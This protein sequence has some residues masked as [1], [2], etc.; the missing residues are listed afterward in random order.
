MKY[1]EIFF[2]Y[3][4]LIWLK[5]K[6]LLLFAYLKPKCIILLEQ[7]K[8]KYHSLLIVF[9]LSGIAFLLPSCLSSNDVEYEFLQCSNYEFFG[10]CSYDSL[11]VLTN[12]VYLQ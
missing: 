10:K 1:L 9:L 4:F 12:A 7:M 3:S 11:S 8:F 2:K 5:T 6:N